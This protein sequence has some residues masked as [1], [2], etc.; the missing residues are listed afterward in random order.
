VKGRTILR[1]GTIIE[2]DPEKVF[3]KTVIKTKGV[4]V[5]Q[6]AFSLQGLT[7]DCIVEYILQYKSEN[8]IPTWIIQRE[9]PVIRSE[10]MW[11][12]PKWEANWNSSQQAIDFANEY[13]TPNYLWLNT[14]SRPRAT[15]LPNLKQTDSL[16][17]ELDF[18]PAFKDEP[19]TVPD[20][21]LK[22]KLICYSGSNTSFAAYWGNVALARDKY[23][24]RF[25][26]KNSEV[27]KIVE[28]FG[29]LQTEDEKIAAAYE[30]VQGNLLNLSY[31][32]LLNKDGKKK[33]PK[34]INN[35][36]DAIK[37]GYGWRSDINRVFIDMLREMNVDA[38]IIYSTGRSDDL[39]VKQAKYWQFDESLV[40]V[41]YD[42]GTIGYFA[43]G[44]LFNRIDQVPWFVEGVDALVAG[45]DEFFLNVPFSSADRNM[46]VKEFSYE[47]DED[48][49]VA[50]DLTVIADGHTARWYRIKIQDEDSTD[51]KKLIEEELEEEVE[52]A[53]VSVESI[54]HLLNIDSAFVIE[55]TLEQTELS[56]TGDKV[57]FKPFD[58]CSDTKDPFY[59]P[60]R[61][62]A[63]LF[64]YGET[65][66][67]SAEFNLAENYT[68]TSLPEGK[69]FTNV[70]GECSV[71]IKQDGSRLIA[72]RT[73][74]LNSPFWPVEMY[75][76]VQ[77]LFQ[78]RQDMSELVVV[79]DYEEEEI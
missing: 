51:H 27:K 42:D 79:L 59:A 53:E 1:D 45:G 35:A 54:R 38:K 9:I 47:I 21:S 2:L 43:P 37:N 23:L 25:C 33:E 66:K 30:W 16:Y 14:Y 11:V 12:L 3:V 73:F 60:E 18:V 77:E 6:T 63:V 8:P 7:D 5:K 22:T 70:V 39:F 34:D 36:N 19:Y 72:Q 64:A 17:F 44:H 13:L 41:D 15:K 61:D 75:P 26:K 50:G 29:E 56:S 68:I 55:C 62:L 52:K 76:D 32:D 31:Q 57:L 4:K 49:S 46:V 67:E 58:Y 10:M 65:T 24:Q 40:L 28:S 69:S 74:K 48:M 78:A 71:T 20:A